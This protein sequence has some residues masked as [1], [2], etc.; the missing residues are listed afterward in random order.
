MPIHEQGRIAPDVYVLGN[1]EM[2]SFLLDGDYP[3]LIDAGLDCL[4]PAYLR[5]IE[6]FLGDR[7]PVRLLLTHSHFDHVGAAP[8]IIRHYPGLEV[9]ASARAAEVLGKPSVQ[10]M[11]GELN[12]ASA[13]FFAG[14]EYDLA[15]GAE[16]EP[17]SGFEVTRV[18]EDGDVL[19]LSPGLNLQVIA[20]P[21]HTRDF[22]CYYVPERRIL[23]TSEAGGTVLP[24]NQDIVSEHLVSYGLYVDSLAR[25]AQRP[26]DLILLGHHWHLVGP[27]ARDYLP[28]SLEASRRFHDWVAG[29]LTEEGGRLEPVMDRVRAE[30]WDDRPMPKQPLGAYL[31][32]LRER[33]RCVRD[34]LGLWA[35]E[36]AA[37]AG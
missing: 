20:A 14:T 35:E 16:F 37:D 4:A 31:L 27:E 24:D 32:N 22:L 15:D 26:A 13:R 1:P 28:R 12:E 5:D 11:I 6:R 10:A 18:L 34:D 8:A 36:P 23:I 3:T 25:L 17:F 9:G 30:E 19:P 29:L 7:P 2:P 33:V 21:G